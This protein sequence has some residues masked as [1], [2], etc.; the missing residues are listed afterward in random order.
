MTSGRTI[1][2][3]EARRCV[4]QLV[5]SPI[6]TKYF[7]DPENPSDR[8]Y[9]RPSTHGR[10]LHLPRMLFSSEIKIVLLLIMNTPTIDG[11]LETQRGWFFADCKTKTK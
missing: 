5:Q 9:L 1:V 7:L 8:Y 3:V 6:T 2:V 11:W 4:R 10:L